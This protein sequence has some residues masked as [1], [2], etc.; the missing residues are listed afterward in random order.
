MIFQQFNL[1]SLAHRLR[2]TSP[3]RCRSPAVPRSRAHGPRRRAAG[4]R[5][6]R[7]QGARLPRAALRRPEAAGR[8]RPRAGHLAAHPA[9]RRGHQ[10]ARPARPPHDV[11]A[12]LK[13]VNAELG[14]TIVVI[15]HE[16]EVVAADRRQGRG[17]GAAAGSSS[18]APV[19]DVF[20]DPQHA[21][22]APLRRARCVD[23][24]PSRQTLARLRERHA[25]RLV[26]RVVP[27]RARRRS[28][29]CS[30]S[31]PSA[32]SQFELVY[33]GIQRARR[34][35]VRQP[36]PR[37]HGRRRRDR[38]R[39]RRGR[40]TRVE[41]RRRWT[42]GPPGAA[43]VPFWQSTGRPSTWSGSRWSSA[44]SVGLVLGVV[45]L[46]HAAAAGSCRTRRSPP[47]Q[48]AGQHLPADP[49]HHLHHRDRSR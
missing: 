41:D 26:T 40:T 3:T 35:H 49:V 5:R 9:R 25:G 38:R 39:A 28:R 44:G 17:D 16:M 21:A 36:H 31:S 11:L 42:D 45:A 15:T 29:R 19:F 10:R 32:T 22:T 18:T 8:H 48:R 37:A 24:G 43:A 23:D 6:A 14:I 27:R 30:P 20:A 2:A 12:L 4:L 34:T 46:R 33:G 7:R 1:F 47:A 13:R